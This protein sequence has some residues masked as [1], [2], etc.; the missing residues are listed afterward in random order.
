MTI[1]ALTQAPAPAFGWYVPSV[2]AGEQF[3]PTGPPAF[4][5]FLPAGEFPP[6][7]TPFPGYGPVPYGQPLPGSPVWGQHYGSQL[8]DAQ[9]SY[10]PTQPTTFQR[11]AHDQPTE[12]LRLMRTSNYRWWRPVLG[13]LTLVGG[14]L[15]AAI[16][17]TILAVLV[18]GLDSLDPARLQ[19]LTDPAVLILTNAS[20]IVAIP[21][22]WLAW[23]VHT[24]R[25]GWASSVRRRIRWG[26]LA[27]YGALALLCLGVGFTLSVLVS[28]GL[29]GEVA[30][31]GFDPSGYLLLAV[32]V[33][34]TTPLQSAAEEFVF[35]GYLSQTIAAWVNARVAGA[36][37]A[38]VLTG[39][40]FSMAHLPGDFL[41]FLDRFAFGVAA[42]AVVWLTGGLEAAIALHAV[43]NMVIF[44]VLGAVGVA[45]SPDLEGDTA[46]AALTVGLDIATMAAYVALVAVLG[47]RWRP[48]TRSAA[49]SPGPDADPRM[50]TP[51]QGPGAPSAVGIG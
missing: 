12:Y 16:V 32:V 28:G 20:L 45:T 5:W 8:A 38:A 48:D 39:A 37:I 41:T 19:D 43:N 33:L 40:L 51:Q 49:R 3:H 25:F 35:R 50:S 9:S 18:V 29:G 17:V 21:V 30:G 6:V 1:P 42:S 46:T 27:R 10:G 23:T 22:V 24:E 15:I 34:A 47:K 31:P 7:A 44:L 14:Y 4:G 13:L 11:V 26:L 36:V 2:R